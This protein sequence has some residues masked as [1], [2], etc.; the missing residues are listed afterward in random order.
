MKNEL[1]TKKENGVC[2]FLN[3]IKPPKNMN[4]GEGGGKH[5]R[6]KFRVMMRYVKTNFLI[7]S[8]YKMVYF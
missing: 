7:F 8:K 3:S 5:N 1:S 4:G 6:V 2:T